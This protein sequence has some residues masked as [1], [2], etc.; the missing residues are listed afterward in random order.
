MLKNEVVI[1]QFIHLHHFISTWVV[2]YDLM[3]RSSWSQPRS[4]LQ[5]KVST[6]DP[7]LGLEALKMKRKAHFPSKSLGLEAGWSWLVGGGERG[8]HERKRGEKYIY[9]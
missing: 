9:I 7:G 6:K 8:F 4:S 5:V 2:I 3:A 1:S